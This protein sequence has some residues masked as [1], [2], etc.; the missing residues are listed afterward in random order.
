MHHGLVKCICIYIQIII[1]LFFFMKVTCHQCSLQLL[2]WISVM[3]DIWNIGQML[4]NNVT[5]GKPITVLLPQGLFG[6]AQK[7]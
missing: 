7:P 1:I 5:F 3:H 2:M 4:K 6:N